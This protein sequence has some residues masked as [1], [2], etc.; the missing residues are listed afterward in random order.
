MPETYEPEDKQVQLWKL[1]ATLTD[2]FIKLLDT[3]IAEL[4][5]STLGEIT[6]FLKD[7]DI[8]MDNLSRMQGLNRLKL[9]RNRD[10]E[11]LNLPFDSSSEEI[12]LPFPTNS[13]I[14]S[15]DEVS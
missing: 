15:D 14:T 9:V 8:T 13:D 10:G 7:N 6:T 12:K 1:H 3:P 4:K 11:I 2:A 5:A